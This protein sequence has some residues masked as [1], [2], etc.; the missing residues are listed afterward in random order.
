MFRSPAERAPEPSRRA[1]EYKD[2]VA[3]YQCGDY[4][5]AF[6]KF[7]EAANRGYIEAHYMV[8]RMYDD[9]KGV[10][11]DYN[12]VVFWYRKAAEQGSALAQIFLGESYSAGNGVPQDYNQAALWFGKAADQG[13]ATAQ[14]K[15]AWM[16]YRG[17]GVPKDY[18]EAHKWFNLAATNTNEKESRDKAIKNRDLLAQL[19]TPTEIAESE[20]RTREWK[21]TRRSLI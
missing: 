10:L 8:G 14:R 21:K 6:V 2:G 3:A 16:Y 5:T 19:M 15:L 9:G 11:Q 12:Q 4:R 18:V 20:K 1:D 13:D 7:M 17:Q